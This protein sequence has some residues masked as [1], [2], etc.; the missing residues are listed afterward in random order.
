M[1]G[2]GIHVGPPFDTSEPAPDSTRGANG[3]VGCVYAS[4]RFLRSTGAEAQ[5]S[6]YGLPARLNRCAISHSGPIKR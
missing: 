1:N 2:R 3:S 5:A 6:Q 4:H